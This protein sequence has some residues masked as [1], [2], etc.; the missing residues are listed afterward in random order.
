MV[1]CAFIKSD[2][3][4]C[5]RN[6]KEGSK[7]CWQHQEV[8]E[9]VKV[10]SPKKITPKNEEKFPIELIKLSKKQL[11][12]YYEKAFELTKKERQEIPITENE[13]K[14]LDNKYEL[15]A[16]N[17]LKTLSKNISITEESLNFI[18][19]L[20]NYVYSKL[21][22]SKN[23]NELIQNINKAFEHEIAKHAIN[24]IQKLKLKNDNIIDLIDVAIF[25]I[26][27]EIIE[28]S[29]NSARDNNFKA[30]TYYDIQ[31][32]L[33]N[34]FEFH[35][36]FKQFLISKDFWDIPTELLDIIPRDLILKEYNLQ[37]LFNYYD[38]NIRSHELSTFKKFVINNYMK[39]K[40]KDINKFT[41]KIVE[42]LKSNLP[43]DF[44]F[45]QFVDQLQA[46]SLNNFR[47]MLN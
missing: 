44:T 37:K 1:Q 21:K 42:Q 30:I 10:S 24:N 23:I 28:L 25:Y 17:T 40:P 11:E 32:V 22:S 41:Q 6:A 8:K 14:N 38:L 9:N 16:Y 45:K 3:T 33:E 39:Y 13:I 46:I 31:R 19:I 5:K 15:Y 20:S 47:G 4:Q 43:K 26:I 34:D 36:F 18:D 7:Y 2:G 12:E 27:D 29:L 35:D